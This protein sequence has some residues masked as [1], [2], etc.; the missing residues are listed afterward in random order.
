M[1]E[2]QRDGSSQPSSDNK[3]EEIEEMMQ[4]R[5]ELYKEFGEQNKNG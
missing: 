4:K 3:Q 5:K 1:L 2:H